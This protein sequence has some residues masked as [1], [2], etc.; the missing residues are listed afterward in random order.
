MYATR[1]TDC[2]ADFQTFYQLLEQN[3]LPECST[4]ELMVHPGPATYRRET[5]LLEGDWR[6]R[7]GRPCRMISYLSL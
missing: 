1:T 7:I 2:L 3:R 5:Q 4:V 6:E